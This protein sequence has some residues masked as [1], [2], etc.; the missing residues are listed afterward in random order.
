VSAC[1]DSSAACPTRIHRLTPAFLRAAYELSKLE[2]KVGSPEK[3]LSDLGKLSYR[4]CALHRM[5][6]IV[7]RIPDIIDTPPSCSYW[8]YV[9]LSTLREHK[10]EA[11][12]IRQLRRGLPHCRRRTQPAAP[13][14]S[15]C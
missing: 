2:G 6:A 14:P 7:S 11:L 10:H 15:P 3:P 5:L 9:I 13:L 1:N 12:S 8:T 4:R